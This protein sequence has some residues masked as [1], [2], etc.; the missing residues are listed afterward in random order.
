MVVAILAFTVFGGYLVAA[1][2]QRPAGPP[3]AVAGTVAV[4]PLSGWEVAHTFSGDVGSGR[5]EGVSLTRGTGNLDVVVI[6]PVPGGLVELGAT[7][8]EQVLEPQA[9]RLSVSSGLELVA[10]AGG[11]D[12]ARFSYV[13]VF[14][15]G[16][17][18]IEGEVTVTVAGSGAGVVFDAWAPQGQL[19]FSLVDAHTMEDAAEIV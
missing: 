17:S 11:R 1:A 15:R 18:P 6:D 8:V 2:L 12:A 3:I 4:Q 14:S 7:F 5:A 10:L 19:G 13:G 9:Q 16:G